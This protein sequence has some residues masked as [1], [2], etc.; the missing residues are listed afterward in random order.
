[1]QGTTTIHRTKTYYDTGKLS[2]EVDANGNPPTTYMY[3]TGSCG[4]AFP[5]QVTDA[6]GF[7]TLFTWDCNGGVMTGTTDANNQTTSYS[8]TDPKYWRLTQ[9]T[10][11][12]GGQK[13]AA[14]NTASTP[15]NIV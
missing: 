4:G 1:V 11:P 6:A 8:W 14:Y 7:N 5:T 13:T 15:W 12:D 9:I 3:G 10:Y 2:T